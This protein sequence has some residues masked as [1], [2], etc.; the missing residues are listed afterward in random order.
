MIAIKPIISSEKGSALALVFIWFLVLTILG[1]TFLTLATYEGKHAVRREQ[2]VRA[3]FRAEGGLNIALWRLN[4]GP[5]I[6][7]TFSNDEVAVTYDSS[8]L[9]L[10]SIGMDGTARCQLQVELFDDHPFNHIVSYGSYLDTH[11]FYITNLAK[12]ELAQFAPMPAVD[13]NYYFNRADFYYI[14]DQIF[15]GAMPAGIHYVNGHVIMKNGTTLNG[16]LVATEGARFI[17]FVTINAQLMPDTN[18]YYP[19]LICADTAMAEADVIGTPQLVIK[20]MVYSTGTVIF[21]GHLLTGPIVADR[22][23]L[24]SGVEINDLG[25]TTYYQYP[26]GFS[27]LVEQDYLKRVIRGSWSRS[28]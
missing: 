21:K 20:G 7:A 18:L 12:K 4:H 10:S 1:T 26:P 27:P 8:S 11:N 14:G 17:G 25:Q 22:I 15:D 24:M 23:V 3:F 28:G 13:M 9:I 16:T 19:A 5:D 6:Y 2:R